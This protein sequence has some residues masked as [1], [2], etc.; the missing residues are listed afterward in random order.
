MHTGTLRQLALALTF[1][2]ALHTSSLRAQV[3]GPYYNGDGLF[4]VNSHG[5]VW[6]VG[7]SSSGSLSLTGYTGAGNFMFWYPGKGAFRA[8]VIDSTSPDYGTAQHEWWDVN[9]GVGSAAFGCDTTATGT[10]SFAAG[11]Q[12]YASGPYSTALGQNTTATGPTSMAFGFETTASGYYSTA[13]GFGTTAS[14]YGS[15]ACGF[16]NTASGYDATAFGSRTLAWGPYSTS[17]GYVTIAYGTGASSFGFQTIAQAY[18]S[19]VIGQFNVGNGNSGSWVSTDPL[20]EIGNGLTSSTKHDALLVDKSGN[21]TA[22]GVMRCS[23]GGDLSMGGFTAGTH[24]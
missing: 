4:E 24:P 9:I 20:F 8:G 5:V 6:S 12:T 16:L 21:V 10:A 3:L 18:G 22:G 1:W 14:G 15:T 13:F 2:L 19:F 7:T 23:P 11:Y 17:S